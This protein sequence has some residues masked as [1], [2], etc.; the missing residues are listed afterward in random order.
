MLEPAMV[1]MARAVERV[2]EKIQVKAAEV[3]A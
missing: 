3:E 1:E 2:V